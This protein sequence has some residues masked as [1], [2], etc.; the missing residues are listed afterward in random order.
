ML[1]PERV[2]GGDIGPETRCPP[3]RGTPT[4]QTTFI[5][6]HPRRSRRCGCTGACA[7]PT[8]PVRA[9]LRR[10]PA[11]SSACPPRRPGR[12]RRVRP[13]LRLGDRDRR[14]RRSPGP[15]R[16]ALPEARSRRAGVYVAPAAAGT[17]HVVA[18]APR[19]SDEVPGRDRVRRGGARGSGVVGPRPAI[20]HRWTPAGRS[21]SGDGHRNGQPGRRLVGE[22][23]TS[24]GNGDSRRRV[25]RTDGR[26]HVPRRGV[27]RGRPHA[28]RRRRRSSSGRRR[29]S[30]S[31]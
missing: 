19:R 2:L 24:R 9:E 14:H 3:P 30:R 1:P 12:A 29:C 10:R 17:Y 21:P 11:S 31:R 20:D 26:R 27:E 8:S 16:R 25:H 15:C 7:G 6:S 13:V 22:G 28:G 23:G 4:M 18:T 5:R